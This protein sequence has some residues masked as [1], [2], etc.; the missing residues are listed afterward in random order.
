MASCSLTLFQYC[1]IELVQIPFIFQPHALFIIF[2]GH[3]ERD[4]F[5]D[6]LIVIMMALSIDIQSYLAAAV[7]NA[8]IA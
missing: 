1:V 7:E 2:A 5:T 8:V 6:P 4:S 3:P